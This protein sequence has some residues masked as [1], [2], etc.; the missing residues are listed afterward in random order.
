MLPLLPLIPPRSRS[1]CRRRRRHCSA[2]RRR[3]RLLLLPQQ[4]VG[5][6]RPAHTAVHTAQGAPLRPHC[7]AHS[8]ADCITHTERSLLHMS[9]AHCITCQMLTASHT[10][11]AH[12]ITQRSSAQC[13]KHQSP[14]ASRYAP[15]ALCCA[16][17]ASC[18][19]CA[20]AVCHVLAAMCHCT[21]CIKHAPCAY[22][23]TH[24]LPA[25]ICDDIA[26]GTRALRLRM[27]GAYVKLTSASVVVFCFGLGL[28]IDRGSIKES[29]MLCFLCSLHTA[30]DS[31]L[32]QA[33]MS[34]PHMSFSVE[35]CLPCLLRVPINL[36]L[37]YRASKTHILMALPSHSVLPPLPC[38]F[39]CMQTIICLMVSLFTALNIWA[40]NVQLA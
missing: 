40:L 23:I 19:L 21:H 25:S 24:V 39:W 38:F 28:R 4:R 34:L 6:H 17:T 5:R 10:P 7:I 37:I 9:S 18:I 36:R 32:Q 8:T 35:N 27:D 1:H 30:A 3:P 2:H 20:T 11:S 16:T 26:S 29:C 14:R 33:R 13:A 15:A 22:R 31:A 12:C